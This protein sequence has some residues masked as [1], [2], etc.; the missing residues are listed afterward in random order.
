LLMSLAHASLHVKFDDFHDFYQH[1]IRNEK[2]LPIESR[3]LTWNTVRFGLEYALTDVFV[4]KTKLPQ[5][6]LNCYTRTINYLSGIAAIRFILPDDSDLVFKFH[7]FDLFRVLPTIP[8]L[9]K[10]HKIKKELKEKKQAAASAAASIASGGKKSECKIAVLGTNGVGKSALVVQCVQGIF[11]E[12]YD[13]TIEDSYRKMM[14]IDNFNVML[15]ILDT[16]NSE[17]VFF[18]NY[19]RD[20]NVVVF[21]VT[22][23]DTFDNAVKILGEKK[24]DPAK[25]MLVGNKTDLDQQRVVTYDTAFQEAVKHGALYVETS[26]K[27]RINVEHAFIEVV[28][29]TWN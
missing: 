19:H 6:I 28:K 1:L 15:E 9:E 3:S 14:Q 17:S 10:A 13:P 22:N 8:Y 4:K 11:V 12:S 5:P 21:D 23:K 20:A 24:A 2:E 26:A 18:M 27:T 29:S 7:N 16:T 25:L